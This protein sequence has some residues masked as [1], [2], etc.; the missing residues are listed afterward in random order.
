M[1]DILLIHGSC[2]GG[3]CWEEVIAALAALGVDARAIDLP[4]RDGAD[5]TLQAQADAVLAALDQPALVV[6]HSAGGFAITAAAERDPARVRGLVYLCAYLPVSG[7]SLADMRRAGPSQ[8]LLPA[9]RVASDRRS[10]SFD[11][12]QARALLYHDCAEAV[13]ARAT[14]RLCAEAVAPQETPLV[15][16]RSLALPRHYIKCT[17]DRAIPPGYLAT[18]AAT[19]PVAARH[20]LATGHSPFF[21]APERLAGLLAQIMRSV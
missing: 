5:T 4:G 14:D 8:P 7:T 16:H 10:F 19:L 3:W 11:P 20:S 2:H 12:V 9:I 18:M 17:G 15:L 21:A 1:S 6:G 13:A